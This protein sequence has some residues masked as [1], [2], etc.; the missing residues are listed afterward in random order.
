MTILGLISWQHYLQAEIC[1][2]SAKMKKKANRHLAMASVNMGLAAICMLSYP[3]LLVSTIPLSLY[4]SLRH[5]KN[6]YRSLFKDKRISIA[7]VDTVLITW[8]VLSGYLLAAALGLFL[9][10]LSLKLLSR[11]KDTSKR[12]LTD[13]FVQHPHSVWIL[14]GDT[15]AEIPFED[16][17]PGD[18][19]VVNAG[20]VIPTDGTITKGIA[21]IDQHTLTGESKAMEKE[22]GEQVFASTVVLS[23][24]IHIRT[25]KAGR[26]TVA[27]QI[28]E[29][30]NRTTEYK[31]LLESK[32]E[33]TVDRSTLPSLILSAL[34]YPVAGISGALAILAS[35][36][37]YSMRILAPLSTSNFL[38]IA[39]QD[40]ILIKDG[41][42]LERL[43]EVDTVIFD[44]TGTLT[45]EELHIR[46]IHSFKGYSDDI[47][48]TYAAAAEYRQKHPLARAIL[49]EAFK[50]KLA[51]PKTD[52]SHYE[53]GYGIK[54]LLSQRAVR[55][56]SR[57]FME[58]EKIVIP[59]DMVPI[60]ESCD[61]QGYSLVMI[62]VDNMF[63]GAIELQ[64]QIRPEAKKIIS[65]LHQDGISTYVI[66]GDQEEPTCK[67][68][69]ELG[70][71]HYYANTLPK[72]KG[73]IV[74][75]L[76]KD[77][78]IV[79]FIGDGIN[80]SIALK[81]ADI[82]ISLRGSTTLATDIAQ[83]IFMDENLTR[84]PDL[85]DIAVKLE[86]NQKINLIISV[87][88]GIICIGGVFFFH[89]GIYTSIA[90]FYSSL[91]A[92][93]WNALKKNSELSDNAKLDTNDTV[94][95]M[96][97]DRA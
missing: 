56:G 5:F 41:R 92:G 63:A 84:F 16:L 7:V 88:P 94:L 3:P 43:T 81:K 51:V 22:A 54:V 65:Q 18:I 97:R 19:V 20:E 69:Q 91:A 49:T 87:V 96:A 40:G 62:S 13:V 53:V 61:I 15:E 6:A 77:G 33:K 39:S 27:A 86:A 74:E 4:L 66:S 34:A 2:K 35:C 47:L 38:R 79:C 25:E 83:I 90:V 58:M 9:S 30:L 89:L 50:R 59:D 70:I 42:A 72:D 21:L 32:T 60:Q 11:T 17:K 68:A 78:K 14:N 80:D 55:V 76:Q 23:G 57:R 67:L 44:K 29:I 95:S 85:L 36:V 75:Q 26:E 24:R 28:G 82:S 45:L 8:S 46:G 12:K 64:P 1:Q 52:D 31:T 73:K 10:V 37:G 48:I 71:N 93:T